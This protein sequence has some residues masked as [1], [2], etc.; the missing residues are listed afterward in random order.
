MTSEEPSKSLD[1]VAIAA[2]RDAQNWAHLV[3]EL[4]VSQELPPDAINL[5][6]EGRRL[7]GPTHGFGKLWRKTY[8]I[9]LAPGTDPK[10]VIATWKRE[11]PRFWPKTSWFYGPVTGVAPDGVGLINITIPGRLKVSS[12]VLV[13]Y[14]DEES[15]T[16]MTVEGHQYAG[17]IT[18]SAFEIDG[19][20]VAQV[21]VLIRANDP[22]WEIGMPIAI[23]RM[24]DKFWIHT[25]NALGD[26]F[27]KAGD[28]MTEVACIDRKRQWSRWRN[29][30]YN[31][32]VRSLLY[33]LAS[34]VRRLRKPRLAD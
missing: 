18:F 17:L 8:R 13:L 2:S 27:G 29:I 31:S 32:L 30:K 11:F 14:A 9:A 20:S 22:L 7:T 1:D 4:R 33:V 3:R 25:L 15:F 34:P 16:F 6:V 21:E 5:N 12:G 23:N 28:V 10:K 24:E 19:Q 26:Y